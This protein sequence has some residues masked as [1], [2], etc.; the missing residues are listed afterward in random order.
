MTILLSAHQMQVVEKLADRVLLMNRGSEVLSGTM[1]EIRIKTKSDSRLGSP[2]Q[3]LHSCFCIN[4]PDGGPVT[5]PLA[6]SLII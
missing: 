5:M 6:G 1:D 4:P 3:G 2:F